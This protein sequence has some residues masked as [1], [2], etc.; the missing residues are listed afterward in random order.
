MNSRPFAQARPRGHRGFAHLASAA[1]AACAAAACA[2]DETETVDGGL[3]YAIEFPSKQAAIGVESLKVYV[4]DAGQDCLGLIQGRR[5]G[6]AFPTP[7][8][9]TASAPLCDYLS[10]AAGGD[11][12]L[13]EGDYVV[14]ALA[15][16][17]SQDYLLGCAR[18]RVDAATERTPVTMT[19][20][21]DSQSVPETTCTL[22]A[23]KCGGRC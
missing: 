9:E 6:A 11:I 13:A 12:E 3:G 21:D 7:L 16:R 20:A 22:L 23:D 15:Q 14:F 5:S 19:L 4:F 1:I 8:A 10:G 2:P 17:E 18:Q